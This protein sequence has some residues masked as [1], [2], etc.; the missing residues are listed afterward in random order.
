MRWRKRK[1][2]S[3]IQKDASEAINRFGTS[4][5]AKQSSKFVLNNNNPSKP[6]FRCG[7]DHWPSNCYFK[8][9]E[10]FRCKESGHVAR[11]CLSKGN[12]VR[13]TH[14]LQIGEERQTNDRTQSSDDN[15]IY[16]IYSCKSRKSSPITIYPIVN[17]ISIPM[18]LDTGSSLSVVNKHVLKGLQK[19]KRKLQLENTNI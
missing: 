2:T 3:D 17:D 1:E 16:R 18:E 6:C 9:K 5:Q 4:D 19:G 12:N 14:S 10:C 8:H 13:S 15:D 7:K 11:L